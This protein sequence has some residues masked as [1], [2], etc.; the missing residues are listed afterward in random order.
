MT[1][2]LK[3]GQVPSAESEN[4]ILNIEE[5]KNFTFNLKVPLIVLQ[6]QT[7]K[8]LTG[9]NENRIRIYLGIEP[10]KE[11]DDFVL[12]AYAIPAFLLGSGDVFRDYESP[13]FKLERENI[14]QSAIT[15][16]VLENIKRY[17]KW[18]MGKTDGD[19][20]Y[21]KFRK[22][23]Y[24]NGYLLSKYELH[25]I[26]NVQNKNEIQINFGISKIMN[27]LIYADIQEEREFSEKTAVF[28]FGDLCPPDCDKS[29]IYNF[30]DEI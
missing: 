11:N 24:P 13:V 5:E 6:K 20:P 23:I 22:F 28:N 3:R 21:S 2:V 19:D 16:Q 12:C 25:E 26:F 15:E 10:E 17:R 27:A 9:E 18:R 7:Y 29:S 30:K 14:N 8:V 1:Q 4:W